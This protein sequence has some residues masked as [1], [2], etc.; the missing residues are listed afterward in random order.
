M[1]ANKQMV[2]VNNR[3]NQVF[4]KTWGVAEKKD[5]LKEILEAELESARQENRRKSM[6]WRLLFSGQ[7][8]D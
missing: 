2:T 1:V 5:K 7:P 3:V 4:F 6:D 8:K